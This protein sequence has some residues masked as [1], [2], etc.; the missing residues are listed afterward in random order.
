[1]KRIVSMGAG[2]M[3]IGLIV[4]MAAELM[5]TIVSMGAGLMKIIISMGARLMKIISSLHH[6]KL[7]L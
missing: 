2:L 5:K 6:W 3:K 1:M 7:D 4:S